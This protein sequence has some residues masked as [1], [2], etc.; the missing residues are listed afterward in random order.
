MSETA[1][2]ERPVQEET[3]EEMRTLFDNKLCNVTVF[4]EKEQ[5]KEDQIVEK[6]SEKRV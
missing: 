6:S 3:A 5:I 4:W 2:P 1:G